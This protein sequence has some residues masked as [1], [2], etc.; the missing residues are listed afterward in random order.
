VL[1]LGRAS[2]TSSIHLRRVQAA[3]EWWRRSGWLLLSTDQI[4]DACRALP[5]RRDLALP[6]SP[7][8]IRT[9]LFSAAAQEDWRAAALVSLALLTGCRLSEIERLPLADVDLDQP[10]INLGGWTKT[11]RGRT[12]D[13]SVCPAAVEILRAMPKTD[14]PTIWGEPLSRTRDSRPIRA[15]IGNV[16]PWT[17]RRLRMT[18][19]SYLANAPGI[20]GGASAYRAARQ[21][22]H[23]VTV[24]ERHYLGVVSVPREATTLEAAMQAATA[25]SIA[26]QRVARHPNGD[27]TG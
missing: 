5:E 1:A 14:G 17:W 8:E 15:A 3:L 12:V 24:A 19:G 21:L 13:L 6:L 11:H 22:G 23:S 20:W 16:V 18:C 4:R 10:A 25:V 2:G 27:Q 26:A 7:E 9:L